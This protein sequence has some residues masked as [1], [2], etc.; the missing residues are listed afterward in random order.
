MNA[1]LMLIGAL[2]CAGCAPSLFQRHLDA[3]RWSEAAQAFASDSALQRNERA[4]FRAALLHGTPGTPVYDPV[5]ARSLLEQLTTQSPRSDRAAAARHLL[6]LFEALDRAVVLERQVRDL[7]R[8]IA[9]Q[10][11]RIE[12]LLL[13]RDDLRDR[14]RTEQEQRESLRLALE[15]LE[16]EL[17]TR[18]LQLRTLRTELDRLKA[19][20]LRLPER[21][22]TV[23]PP[24]WGKDGATVTGN[25]G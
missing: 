24:H 11:A 19:I 9:Q 6:P 12:R 3:H 13:E 14:L 8:E 2:A 7:E 20:D 5:R 17:R 15:S 16:A 23:T 4:L 10:D 25:G 1:R 18:D 22:V 21:P